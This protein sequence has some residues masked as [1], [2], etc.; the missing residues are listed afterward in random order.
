MNNNIKICSEKVRRISVNGSI[1]FDE[2]GTHITFTAR[3]FAEVTQTNELA[4]D[5]RRQ[6]AQPSDE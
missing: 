1:K 4:N 2:E 3:G 5:S 6:L